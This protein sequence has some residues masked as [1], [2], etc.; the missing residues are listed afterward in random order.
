MFT[1]DFGRYGTSDK[2]ELGANWI[3]GGADK[4]SV[5]TFAL[6]NHLLK[7]RVYLER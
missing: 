7:Q 3:H 6:D 2:I 4:N 1:A 5:F